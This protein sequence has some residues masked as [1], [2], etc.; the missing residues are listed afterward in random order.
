MIS[1]YKQTVSQIIDEG[2]NIV[3]YVSYPEL[4]I[5]LVDFL[6]GKGHHFVVF[7]LV[8][9]LFLQSF[10]SSLLAFGRRLLGLNCDW[11]C[12]NWLSSIFVFLWLFGLELRFGAVSEEVWIGSENVLFLEHYFMSWIFLNQVSCQALVCLSD[13]YSNQS[14]Q[15]FLELRSLV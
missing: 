2:F 1:C 12:C 3:V 6:M 11:F 8:T 7:L 5:R 4:R 10:L 14:V 9:F 13:I 15:Y